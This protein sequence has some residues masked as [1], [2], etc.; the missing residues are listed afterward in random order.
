M[1]KNKAILPP[2]G[3]PALALAVTSMKKP[4]LAFLYRISPP[5]LTM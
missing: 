2:V 1:S 3:L 5:S 4:G